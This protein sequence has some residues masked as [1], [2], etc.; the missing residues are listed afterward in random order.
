METL[1][2]PETLNVAFSLVVCSVISSVNIGISK[3]YQFNENQKNYNVEIKYCSVE[4]ETFF[5]LI[6]II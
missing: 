6:R 3:F 1:G 4:S 5:E 2:T